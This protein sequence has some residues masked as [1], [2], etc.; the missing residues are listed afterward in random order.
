MLM[1]LGV[2]VRARAHEAPSAKKHEKRAGQQVEFFCKR[3]V[4]AVCHPPVLSIDDRPCARNPAHRGGTY[5]EWVSLAV[6]N[7][8]FKMARCSFHSLGTW[9]ARASVTGI[10]PATESRS[11]GWRVGWGGGGDC[12]Q[13][14]SDMKTRP[15]GIGN[16]NAD[17]MGS[18]P[19]KLSAM[20]L[21]HLA[22][23][24]EPVV[25]KDVWPP[26]TWIY[27]TVYFD[28]LQAELVWQECDV[29][30]HIVHG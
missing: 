8:H 21:K 20:P 18:L 15:A 16:V 11:W 19:S 29:Q 22:V 23:P 26:L 2:W 7:E 13:A 28:R 12:W 10:A 24:G 5:R 1:Y 17:W 30:V 3:I 14:V 25:R 9:S 27:F 4:P 6:L